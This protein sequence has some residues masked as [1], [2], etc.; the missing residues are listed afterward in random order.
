MGN[1]GGIEN[2]ID[3]F[4]IIELDWTARF[5]VCHFTFLD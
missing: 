5:I 1:C 2:K 3:E 4:L